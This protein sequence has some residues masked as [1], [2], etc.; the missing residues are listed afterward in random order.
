M[1][2][3]LLLLTTVLLHAPLF[4]QKDIYNIEHIPELRIHFPEANWDFILDSLKQQGGKQRI[5]AD[6]TFDGEK[7]KDIGIRYKGNSS[8]FNVR[9]TGSSK[10][11]FN[12]KIDYKVKEQTLPG[13]ITKLKLANVFRDPSFL[14]EMLSYEIARKYMPAP[15]ANFV[16]V[17]AN[18][19]YLGLYSNT[20]S[21]EDEFLVE[22]FGD[23]DGSLFKCDPDWRLNV[24]DT[25]PKGDKAS[26][27]YLG[28]DSLCY[29]ASYELDADSGWTDLI[30][31]TKFLHENPAKIDSI[32]DV[33]QV[34]WMLAFNSVLVNLD[35][36]TGMLC[37][38][39]YLYRDLNGG[40]HPVVWDMNLSFGAFRF[41]GLDKLPLRTSQMQEMSPFIHYKQR[42]KKRPLITNLLGNDLYRKIYIAH[43]K[44]ILKENFTNQQYLERARKVH[45]LIEPEV[46][47]DSNKL[48]SYEAFTQN[49]STSAKAGKQSIVG[50]EELMS[51]RTEYLLGHS[52]IQKEAPKITKVEH[53]AF[54]ADVVINASIEGADRAWL[55][56]RYANTG[57]FKRLEMF[58]DSGHNDEMEADGI[59]GTTLEQGE[60]IQYYVVAEGSAV[61]SL[62]PERASWEFYTYKRPSVNE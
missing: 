4:S 10:L 14:R 40:Y 25:C 18:D 39:Y 13:G 17:F 31:L 36:Y 52:L 28:E 50:I 2:K 55:Y 37:H 9:K 33:D 35:S 43:I 29:M 21:I 44:T 62:S 24:P 34:M 7:Y 30:Y 53:L 32:L 20:E 46:K 61:A 49:I 26:L 56:Y 23:S 48:Y 54:D 60:E 58:D 51:K 8:Y 27:M 57:V 3:L 38:N 6:I 16:K 41:A 1:K 47:L 12:I 45:K 11:P 59:W 5:L 19:V 15:R 42:N 22:N